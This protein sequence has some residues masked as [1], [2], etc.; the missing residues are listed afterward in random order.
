MKAILRSY[1]KDPRGETIAEVEMEN[2]R[3]IIRTSIPD[4]RDMLQSVMGSNGEKFTPAD[5]E[6]YIRAL[7]YEYTGS[8]LRAE[9][10]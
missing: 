7:P 6:N 10:V 1:G 2:G 5:G 4:V 8:R 3:V 9:I